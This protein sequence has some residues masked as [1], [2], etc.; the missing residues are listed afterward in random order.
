MFKN[1]FSYVCLK[2]AC[3]SI[4]KLTLAQ[5]RLK[6]K[7]ILFY[8]IDYTEFFRLEMGKVVDAQC[9]LSM[10]NV[11]PCIKDFAKRGWLPW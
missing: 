8:K 3:Y 11:K 1:L 2:I 9:R 10:E 5:K 7:K 6:R 4:N